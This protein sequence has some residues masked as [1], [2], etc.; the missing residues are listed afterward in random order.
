MRPRNATQNVRP[1]TGSA[2]RSSVGR[3]PFKQGAHGAVAPRAVRLRLFLE[4]Y[5]FSARMELFYP[6][7]E[8]KK[9]GDEIRGGGEGTSGRKVSEVRDD[10]GVLITEMDGQTESESRS[11][12]S[13]CLTCLLSFAER[14][15][16]SLVCSLSASLSLK[17]ARFLRTFCSFFSFLLTFP[18]LFGDVL[19]TF[20]HHRSQVTRMIRCDFCPLSARFCVISLNFLLY[21][22][23][24]YGYK[25]SMQLTRKAKHEQVNKL[26][27]TI[28]H[29]CSVPAL[30]LCGCF[31]V[32]WTDVGRRPL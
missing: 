10:E 24:H 32:F 31:V 25:W 1:Q 3:T 28:F 15:F 2:P 5:T 20:A 14:T 12:G 11:C 4:K 18:S 13:L 30:S 29:H 17:F 9:S 27:V 26:Q 7:P 16:C 23:T 6:N 21:F 8:R 19:L 22:W